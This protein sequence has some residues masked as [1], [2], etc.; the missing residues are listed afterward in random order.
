MLSLCHIQVPELLATDKSSAGGP[1]NSTTVARPTRL[2]KWTPWGNCT[3]PC[4]SGVQS[5]GCELLHEEAT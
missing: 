1:E 2:W 3:K 4:G 5:R